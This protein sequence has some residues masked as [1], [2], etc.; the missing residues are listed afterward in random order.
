MRAA[1]PR[2]SPQPRLVLVA[3]P[4]QGQSID[5]CLHSQ[6]IEDQDLTASLPGTLTVTFRAGATKRDG[7]DIARCL[8]RLPGSPLK[9]SI[10]AA[11]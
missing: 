3:R 1:D 8:R 10:D 6:T 7:D 5:Q 11:G 4:I 2:S 9:V